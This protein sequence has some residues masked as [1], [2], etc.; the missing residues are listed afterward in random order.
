[1]AQRPGSVVV[2]LPGGQRI[3]RSM[4]PIENQPECQACHNPAQRLTGLL[5]TDISMTPLEVP[6]K[7]DLRENLLWWAGTILVTV[8]I[9]N[10]ALSRLVIRRLER[11]IH[12]LERFGRGQLDIRLPSEGS[13]QIGQLVATFNEMGKRIQ[14]EEIK[15]HELSNDLRRQ[16]TQR[17]DLLKRLITA[18]EEERRRVARNLHDD[19]G[20]ELAGVAVS[21]E[22]IERML[23]DHPEQARAQLQQTRALIS[24]TT[25]RA[26]SLIM[27]LRPSAL[28][29]LG[30]AT[31]LRAHAERT[32]KDTGIQFE[33]NAQELSRRMP[34]EIEIALFRTF[35]EALSN[36]IRHSGAQKVCVSL[37][38]RNGSFEGEVADDGQ[39]FDRFKIQTNGQDPRGLGLLGMQERIAQCGGTLEILSRPGAG[40]RL[41]IQIPLE[42]ETNG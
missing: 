17:Q 30:L 24:K 34:P 21:I 5:L 11:V 10:L 7:A 14:S 2:T 37:S 23:A 33:L 42:N 27:A 35:Q 6:L 15:N 19:L 8:I 32:L 3:F 18:Q 31:A 22:V 40:T 28:D 4:N 25:N 26:Y 12:T 9:V 38:E 20:Q 41:K 16:V 1:M 36:I 39:G 13:D 29:D